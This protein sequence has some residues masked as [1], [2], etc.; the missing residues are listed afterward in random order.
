M[1][2]YPILSPEFFYDDNENMIG[3]RGFLIDLMHILAEDLNFTVALSRSIDDK[4]GKETS[5]GSFNGMVGMLARNETDV[6]AAHLTITK[7]RSEVIDYTIPWKHSVVSLIVPVD[8]VQTH[9]DVIVYMQ[10]WKDYWLVW[11]L[12]GTGVLTFAIAFYVISHHGPSDLHDPSHSDA[13]GLLQSGALSMQILMQ[14]TY[15]VSTESTSA[16]I[17]FI[18]ACI[19]AYM[20]FAH[21]HADITVKMTTGPRPVPIRNFQDVLDNGYRVITRPSTSNSE[22][23]RTAREGTPMRQVWNEMR[24]DPSNFPLKVSEGLKIISND[25][26]TLFW[27]SDT[28]I[29]GNAQ[30]EHLALEDAVHTQN[31]W[32]LQQ[33]GQMAIA[34]FLDCRRLALWA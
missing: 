20:L 14:L 31:G 13:F 8:R 4:F 26:K 19:S 2:E 17:A 24:D 28:N 27:A 22:L 15:R 21:W 25:P 29:L 18:S 32:G 7:D 33:G 5:N 30:Y 9:N 6:V 11:S 23:L 16:R 3:G 1:I 34:N 10:V 12:I